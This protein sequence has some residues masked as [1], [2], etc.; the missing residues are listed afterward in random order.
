ML[1]LFG[2]ACASSLSLRTVHALRFNSSLAAK[3][4]EKLKQRAAE[5]GISDVDELKNKLAEDIQAKKKQMN[6]MDPLKELEAFEKQQRE[7]YEADKARLITDRGAVDPK[8]PQL[9]Y[10]TL[11]S[12]IDVEKVAE[13]PQSDLEAIWKA[14]FASGER[15]LSAVVDGLTFANIYANAFRNPSFILPIPKGEDGY[16]MHYVQWLFPGPN[17][18]HCLFT[19]VAEYKLHKEFAKPHTTLMFHSEFLED[20]NVVL[21]NGQVEKDVAIKMDEAQL[22]VL[23]VQRF[24]GGRDEAKLAVLREFT[25]GKEDFDIKKLVEE[26]TKFD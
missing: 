11:N 21:M 5:L 16:E 10:K 23:N 25:Q 6:A 8:A 22:N 7:E 17:A 14:R 19:T 15:T 26:A 9:P 12:Y 24:Y 20:K 4:Q 18:T 1:R 13:L 3:Y 2:K